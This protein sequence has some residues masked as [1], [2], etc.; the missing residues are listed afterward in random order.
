VPVLLV[1]LKEDAIAGADLFDR[2]AA[3]LAAADAFGDE[4]RLAE[5]VGVP[6]GSGAWGECTRPP[7]LRAG[8]GAATMVSTYT[9][10]VNQSAG[11]L[12]VSVRC[13]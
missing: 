3:A 11:P 8:A 10:P 7:W 6:G 5:W 2:P 9:S 4:D 1:G 12:V 13:G